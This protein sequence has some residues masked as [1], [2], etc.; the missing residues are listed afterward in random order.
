[1]HRRLESQF[2]A[3]SELYGGGLTLLTSC[4]P[5]FPPLDSRLSRLNTAGA[6]EGSTL[7][8]ALHLAIVVQCC[9]FW[10]VVE[11]MWAMVDED[12]PDLAEQ[13]YKALLS[14]SRQEQGVPYQE[15]SAKA[16]GW[17]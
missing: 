11:T 14:T 15:R 4:A 9:G 6:S 10:S 5:I 8:K 7:D 17:P 3:G 1:I 2:E 16:S 12:G 13:F